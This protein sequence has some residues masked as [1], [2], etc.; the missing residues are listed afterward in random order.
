MNPPPHTTSPPPE[1]ADQQAPPTGASETALPS[2]KPARGKV[3]LAALRKTVLILILLLLAAGLHALLFLGVRVSSKSTSQPTAKQTTQSILLPTSTQARDMPDQ[4]RLVTRLF[5]PTIL[6]KPHPQHGFSTILD[7]DRPTPATSPP[8]L[9]TLTDLTAERPVQMP[10]LIPS[11]TSLAARI[12]SIWPPPAPRPLG[13]PPPQQIPPQLLW[14]TAAGTPI[15]GLP[16][17][18]PGEIR[19]LADSSIPHAP[20]RIRIERFRS[21]LRIRLTQS[22]G[23]PALDYMAIRDLRKTLQPILIDPKPPPETA[24]NIP[25][26]LLPPADRHV[27]I[28]AEWRPLLAQTAEENDE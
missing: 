20:T 9:P 4:L 1:A 8:K 17:H 22:C 13:V 2:P 28:E 6:T 26:A 18:L 5:D 10:S 19:E 16:P 24:E 7:S 25:D 11:Q 12:Q 14:R 23:I 15:I 3:L 27:E 21:S